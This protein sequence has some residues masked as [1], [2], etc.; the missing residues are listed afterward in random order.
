MECS[1]IQDYRS[2]SLL[3]WRVT[4]ISAT[5]YLLAWLR[6]KRGCH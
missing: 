5:G 2:S 1:E 6:S 3:D 4:S